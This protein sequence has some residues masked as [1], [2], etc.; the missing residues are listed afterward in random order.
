[1]INF[2]LKLK[3]KK[4]HSRKIS[5]ADIESST[6]VLFTLF[7]RYGDTIISIQVIKEFISKYPNKEYLILCPEQMK[8]YINQFLGD[9]ECIAFNKRNLIKFIKVQFFLKKWQP[10]IGFNPWSNG[11][12]SCF[13]IS[14]C[15]HF[16]CYMDFPK[17]NKENHYEIVRDYLSLKSR[18]MR[19]NSPSLPG[20]LI[21]DNI[22]ICPDSTDPLRSMESN[23]ISAIVEKILNKNKNA[24]ITVA[25][26]T[27]I[28]QD[29]TKSFVFEKTPKSSAEFIKK[30]KS[31]NIVFVADSAPMHIALSLK[32]NTVVV[33]KSTTKE[34]ILNAE[35]EIVE[36]NEFM[37][38]EF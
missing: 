7:T 18:P 35:S 38:Q 11:Y 37:K 28:N 12:D 16:F 23:D 1:M 9:I 5:K 34:Q 36:F 13:F 4:N 31:A 17:T 14:F 24:L 2:Y 21:F 6:K 15:K 3:T 8:P 20:E 33:L 29:K 10:D 26:M 22:L 32:K 19:I 27:S 30:I 25:S